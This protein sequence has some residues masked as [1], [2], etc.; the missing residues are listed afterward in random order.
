MSQAEENL[1]PHGQRIPVERVQIGARMEKI[2]SKSSKLWQN[3]LI[4]PLAICLKGWLYMLSS[5]NIPLA[6]KPSNALR[7]SRK[8]MG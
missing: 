5:K 1:S 4:S 7:S 2:W 8:F 6:R 3:I